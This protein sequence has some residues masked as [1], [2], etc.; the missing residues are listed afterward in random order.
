MYILRIGEGLDHKVSPFLKP[1]IINRDQL[2]FRGRDYNDP[3][4][5]G[6]YKNQALE[7][8]KQSAPCDSDDYDFSFTWFMLKKV[9]ISIIAACLPLHFEG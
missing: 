2:P 7:T 6:P 9:L 8:L 1:N 3:N 5:I 4:L